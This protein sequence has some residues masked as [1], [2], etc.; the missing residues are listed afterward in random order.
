MIKYQMHQSGKT[1]ITTNKLW[2]LAS[3]ESGHYLRMSISQWI[4]IKMKIQSLF[5]T[6]FLCQMAGQ[7]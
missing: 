4:K 3:D 6:E 7:T 5:A 1:V 2:N